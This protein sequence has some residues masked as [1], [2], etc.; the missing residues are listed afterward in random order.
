MAIV[1]LADG[2]P[3]D[4]HA[5]DPIGAFAVFVLPGLRITAARGQ[6]FDIV[7]RGKA[8]IRNIVTA[9]HERPDLEKALEAYQKVE[10][11]I[12]RGLTLEQT[13][14]ELDF[15]SSEKAF[16]GDSKLRKVL[17]DNYM[18]APTIAAAYREIKA[19][20]ASR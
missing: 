17:W 3:P 4:Q 9:G 16:C 15:N 11:A 2:E 14:R 13:Q 20:S 19:K 7:P 18:K 5:A 12:K 1:R 8:R 6:D 10:D